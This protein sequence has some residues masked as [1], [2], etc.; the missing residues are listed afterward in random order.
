MQPSALL[1]NNLSVQTGN[2][3]QVLACTLHVRTLLA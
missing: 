2:G 1:N 3:Q